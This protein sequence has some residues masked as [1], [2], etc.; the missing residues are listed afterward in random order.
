MP[1]LPE[2]ET[3]RRSLEQ[4]LPGR[5]IVD[6]E[7]R[8]PRLRQLVDEDRLRQLLRN[9]KV[10]RLTRRAKY[11][12]VHLTNKKARSRKPAGGSCLLLHL[13]MTG[14][15]LI[16]PQ[17]APL[18]KHDHVIF[19]LDNGFE[20]RF[21]DPRRF[22]SVA[23]VEAEHL[24]E[25]ESLKHLGVE[26]LSEAFTPDYLFRRSRRSKK[27]VKNLLMDQQI[28][29]GVGNIYASESLFLAGVHPLCAA[30]RLSR[31]RF[32]KIHAAI[33]Q[34]LQEA[35]TAGGTTISDFR[36]S[37]GGSGYF[38][39]KLRAYGRAGA[40]CLTCRT[41]IRSQVLAGRSTFYCPKCQR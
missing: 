2:V 34:V 26:P 22:G 27:P 15:V 4:V 40:P 20:L 17:A 8:E 7:V 5:V 1:E 6:I 38:Q 41:P 16:V 13:G 31:R 19:A 21:R 29:V 11:C 23:A 32:E 37:G 10:E 9:Y 3:V 12:I 25:H 14:Q 36:D 39:T 18:D 35:I 33:Q 28:V 24:A 30:G